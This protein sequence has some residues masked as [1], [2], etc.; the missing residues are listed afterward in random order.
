M[1]ANPYPP[2]DGEGDAIIDIVAIAKQ[3]VRQL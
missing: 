2:C 3:G 1:R